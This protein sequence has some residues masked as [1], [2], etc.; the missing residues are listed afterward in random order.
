MNLFAAIGG[1]VI[2]GVIGAA[3]WAAISYY[4]NYEIGY[5]AWGIGALVGFCVRTGARELNGFVPALIAVLLAAGSIVGG[6]YAVATI[7]A[8]DHFGKLEFVT[9]DT[10]QLTRAEGLVGEWAAQ[11]KPLNWPDGK[12]SETAESLVDYPVDVQDEVRK[13]WNALSP[14]DQQAEVEKM[15]ATFAPLFESIKAGAV[16]EIFK[17]SFGPYD[18]LWLGLAC[19][20]AWNLGAGS[21]ETKEEADAEPKE[22]AT[23]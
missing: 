17:G 18:L 10:V 12:N 13:Q 11:N 6:K 20:T 23:A 22:E 15:K 14:A 1:G 19:Y 21:G 3:I 9:S 5:I 8:Q 7:T 16:N 2:G 4:T